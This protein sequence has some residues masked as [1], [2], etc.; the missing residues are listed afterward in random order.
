MEP[1]KLGISTVELDFRFWQR[2]PLTRGSQHRDYNGSSP[3]RKPLTYSLETFIE[4]FPHEVISGK[5]GS[6]DKLRVNF[7]ATVPC[8]MFHMT[9]YDAH[10]FFEFSAR[11]WFWRPDFEDPTHTMYVAGP[12]SKKACAYMGPHARSHTL[13][14]SDT[15]R[16]PWEPPTFVPFKNRYMFL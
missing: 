2:C 8:T 13:Q 4:F 14:I 6:P 7:I 11:A 9:G 15:P 16:P 1:V 3:I 5:D 12:P 10:R